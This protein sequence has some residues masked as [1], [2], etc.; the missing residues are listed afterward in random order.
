MIVLI[1]AY[2]PDER[3]EQLV[4]GLL[5]LG[6]GVRVLVVDDG[7]GPAYGQWFEGARRAG[8]TVLAHSP[9][10]GKG[11]TLK[12]GFAYASEHFPGEPVVCA[13][14]DGQHT[15]ADIQRVMQAL[16]DHPDSMI[17]GSRTFAGRVPLRSRFGNALT[18]KLFAAATHLS[19]QDTQT[20]LR[21]Y[22]AAL[23]PWLQDIPGERF[24]YELSVLLEAARQRVPV[25]EVTIETIYL[26]HNVSSHFRPMQDSVRIYWPLLKFTASSIVAFTIDTTVLLLV[27]ALTGTVVFAAVIA[28]VV[29]ATVNFTTNRALVFTD[30]AKGRIGVEATQYWLLVLGLFA[31]NVTLLKV[32]TAVGLSLLPAKLFTELVLFIGSFRVQRSI[33]FAGSGRTAVPDRHRA[34]TTDSASTGK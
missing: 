14:C 20:G 3:L 33:I 6:A 4:P 9:N 2:Q 11:H 21:A 29:S 15:P 31:V 16:S 30:R 27:H 32:L 28:R 10:R 19:V 13:D 12:E 8:A 23:L 24:E 18:A 26:D 22:P 7:S 17:L 5:A 34:A 1:P 25:R